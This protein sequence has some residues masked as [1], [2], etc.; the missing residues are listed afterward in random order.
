M[1]RIPYPDLEK[2]SPEAREMLGRLPSPANIF[3]MMAHADTCLKPVMKLGGT[4][5]GKLKLDPKLR[6]LCLLHA[7][8]LEGGE[9]EW[10][11]HIP[12]ALDLG[13]T[14]AQVDALATGDDGAACFD[15]REKA[16][17][18]F[19]REVVVNV[20]S[21]EESLAEVRRHLSD[22]EVTELILMAGFYIMLARL[23]ETLGVENE[24]PMGSALIRGIEKRV[25]A[26]AGG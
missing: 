8:K 6:E 13:A 20:R 12:I 24:A 2:A 11:Q 1:A 4:L 3:N 15:A 25:K 21:S 23:T 18:R 10:L 14:Q 19:V 9:Y 22:R 17:L 16:A 5:L 7:V 26:K